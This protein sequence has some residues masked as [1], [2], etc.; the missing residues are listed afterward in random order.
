VKWLGP[1]GMVK[2]CNKNDFT[3]HLTLCAIGTICHGIRQPYP[4]WGPMI[5][6][7]SFKGSKAKLTSQVR[8]AKSNQSEG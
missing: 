3:R 4:K 7:G 6:M 2:R 5:A 8:A 1:A